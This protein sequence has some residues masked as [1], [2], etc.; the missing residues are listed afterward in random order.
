MLLLICFRTPRPAP[1]TFF[2]GFRDA[3]MLPV[4]CMLLLCCF[5]VSCCFYVAFMLLSCC[6]AVAF[7]LLPYCMLLFCCFLC[8]FY[9]AFLVFFLAPRFPVCSPT[10]QLIA[11]PAFSH[12]LQ[13]SFTFLLVIVLLLPAPPPFLCYLSSAQGDQ[14]QHEE[15]FRLHVLGTA[16]C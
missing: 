4:A 11:S 1:N 8:C 15:T 7:L 16:G 3:V 13:N 5:L 2:C 12:H 9:V 14:T 6:F 10:W